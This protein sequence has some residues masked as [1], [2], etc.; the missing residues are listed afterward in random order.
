MEKRK[1]KKNKTRESDT[2]TSFRPKESWLPAC[3]LGRNKIEE[4]DGIL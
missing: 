4:S 1:Q 2:L 3:L